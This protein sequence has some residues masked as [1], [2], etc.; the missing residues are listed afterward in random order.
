[1]HRKS[2]LT[3]QERQAVRQDIEAKYA[4]VAQSPQGLFRYPTGREGLSL[5]RYDPDALAKLPPESL[6]GYAGVANPWRALTLEPGQSTLDV[7][8]GAGL[9]VFVA[10]L[11]PGV[12]A[13]GVDMSQPML[14]RARRQAETARGRAFFARADVEKLPFAGDRFDAVTSNGLISLVPDKKAAFG[15]IFRVLRPG[16][17]LVF[18]DQ[19]LN[20]EDMRTRE[21]IVSSWF[22]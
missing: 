13:L 14:A 5:L 4:K 2:M 3:D 17:R 10:A 7:G 11:T 22:R 20:A 8:C 6:D 19:V 12:T 15:E 1:M 16:G 21:E 9:D 18:G